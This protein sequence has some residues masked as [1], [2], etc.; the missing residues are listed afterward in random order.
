M[1]RRTFIKT[2]VAAGAACAVPGS[3]SLFPKGL[4]AKSE[5]PASFS[6]DLLTDD[7]DTAA[8]ALEALIKHLRLPATG[9]KYQEMLISGA[10]VADLTFVENNRLVDY[11]AARGEVAAQ[12]REV[13]ARFGLPKKIENPVL[14]SF[15]S[16][17]PEGKADKVLVF[18]EEHLVGQYRLDDDVDGAQI[19]GAKGAVILRVKQKRAEV[20]WSSCK[21]KTCMKMGRIGKPGQNL[22]CI[23]N[24]VRV[25]IAGQKASGIDALS[26]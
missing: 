23:P 3:L 20:V 13:A 21:H 4:Y 22:I 17:M 2:C 15:A 7:P 18:Q 12:L 9:L 24:R 1:N 6:L 11:R 14:V 26:F 8:R 16:A 25:A 19:P 5:Q 10:Q